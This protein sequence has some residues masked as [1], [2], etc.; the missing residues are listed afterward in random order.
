MD[1]QTRFALFTAVGIASFSAGLSL[2][3]AC[4]T[5]ADVKPEKVTLHPAVPSQTK[6][7][8]ASETTVVKTAELTIQAPKP[9]EK[10]KLDKGVESKPKTDGTALATDQVS[11]R[12][13]VVTHAVNEREPIEPAELVSGTP[14]TAFVELGNE[15]GV[16]RNVTVTFE[17]DGRPKVGHVKLHVPAK[18]PRFRTWARTRNVTEPGT[19]EAVITSDDGKELGRQPFEVTE[20]L[21]PA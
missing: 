6:P 11:V 3:T 21:N 16:E 7:L 8:P 19:W 12:R 15:D 18:S 14:I 17:R 5:H 13:L 2:T 1:L 9:S 20:T 10:P 4:S